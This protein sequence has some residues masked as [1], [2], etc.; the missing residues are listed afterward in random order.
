VCLIN[1]SAWEDTAIGFD[2]D[3]SF[4]ALARTPESQ[5]EWA[6]LP[7]TGVMPSVMGEP[8][9]R[10]MTMVRPL[11]LLLRLIACLKLLVNELP[12]NVSINHHGV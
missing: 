2:D 12:L 11:T 8:G 6:T 9:F 10:D 4:R 3:R 1:H 5:G 7:R